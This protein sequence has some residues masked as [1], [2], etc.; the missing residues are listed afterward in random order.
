MSPGG[1]QQSALTQ[2]PRHTQCCLLQPPAPD[3]TPGG[4]LDSPLGLTLRVQL[5]TKSYRFLSLTSGPCHFSPAPLPHAGPT[6]TYVSNSKLQGSEQFSLQSCHPA[7]FSSGQ[8]KSHRPRPP[9]P[10]CLPK[11][12]AT[13]TELAIT[14]RPWPVPPPSR[15]P[16]PRSCHHTFPA[17][18]LQFLRHT[19]L[20]LGAFF[21]GRL[22][23]PGTIFLSPAPSPGLLP[24]PLQ[25]AAPTLLAHR[26]T[27]P[28][29][30]K[31]HGL[32][33]GP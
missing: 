19:M 23:L 4:V 11:L 25:V 17:P 32:C 28:D 22:L 18:H 21:T 7:V 14:R 6:V 13:L 15:R 20:S 30:P 10:R 3:R 1:P 9:G 16:L 5:M 8:Q 24:L 31:P 29:A 33:C 2:A 12:P 26:Q 27:F